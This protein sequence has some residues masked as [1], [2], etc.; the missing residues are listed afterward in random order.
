MSVQFD[1]AI[2]V[3]QQAQFLPTALESIRVQQQD[4][5]VAIMD[6][7]PDDSVQQVLASYP[8]FFKYNRYGRDNGQAEAIQEGWD[9][10]QGDIVAWLCADD[11]YFPNTIDQ[12]RQIFSEHPDIDVVYGNTVFVDDSGRF[13]G[14][15]PALDT[16]IS[17]IIKKCSI[18]QPSCFVRRTALNKVG[19]LDT[20]L[21]YIMDWD[22]WTR[23]Y[24]AGMKFYYLDG[25]L[26]VVRMYPGTKTA[27]RS[28][29]RFHEI[30][31]HLFRNTHVFNAIKSFMHFYCYDLVNDKL[32]AVGTRIAKLFNDYRHYR[33]Q[34][35]KTS[36][37][38]NTLNHGFADFGNLVEPTVDI[39]LPWYSEKHP[40]LLTVRC[41]EKLAPVAVL[42]SISLSINNKQAYCYTIPDIDLTSHL[43]HLQISSATKNKWH[44]E[45]VSIE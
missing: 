40:A 20:S 6:A 43:L 1:I 5:N 21:H 31:R 25:F 4:V 18:S 32:G 28:S 3:Y 39:F 17:V 38:Y 12:V 19:G 11:Y 36:K 13:L 41:L 37:V 24:K 42:N 35:K 23:L 29:H 34:Q 30:A 16:D 44:L 22:L 7:S 33:F 27:S 14:Y 10:L 15:F 9:H 45:S 26:S 8:G 2:P